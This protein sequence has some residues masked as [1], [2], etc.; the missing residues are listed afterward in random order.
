MLIEFVRTAKALTLVAVTFCS[1][2]PVITTAGDSAMI[3][4]DFVREN[5]M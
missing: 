5:D 2:A 4:R 1:P 3:G